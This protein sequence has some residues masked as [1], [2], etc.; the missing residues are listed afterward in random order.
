MNEKDYPIDQPSDTPVPEANDCTYHLTKNEL[1][2]DEAIQQVHT[3]IPNVADF[4][5]AQATENQPQE[6]TPHTEYEYSFD[7]Q[8]G[9]YTYTD[10]SAPQPDPVQTQKKK[11]RVPLFICATA[12]VLILSTLT[13]IVG[14]AMGA[15]AFAPNNNNTNLNSPVVT[16][17]IVKVNNGDVP[18][19]AMMQAAAEAF[20]S[21]VVI[22]TFASQ[23]AVEA[24]EAS[25]AGSGVIWTEDGYIVTCN[26]VVD[27]YSLIRVTLSD[28][29]YYFA[30][31]VGT[32][33]KTDLAVLKIAANGKL[34]SVTIRGTDL[35]L[36]E[37]VAIPWACCPI[38]Y[39]AAF[40]LASPVRSELKVR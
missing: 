18:Q 16:Q 6:A 26:H 31:V 28:G 21:V 27:G 3:F 4:S 34:P 35:I 15:S 22:D 10:H 9:R 25:G 32:D 13:G 38:P 33:A 40:S 24:D 1:P 19:S 20:D 2:A 7:S 17:T 12:L 37:S 14:G 30:D 36:A 5:K 23:A 11:N 39:P 29:S 8:S